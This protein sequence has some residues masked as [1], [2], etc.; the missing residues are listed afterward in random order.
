MNGADRIKERIIT[1]AKGRAGKI[2]EAARLEAQGIIK[3]AEKQAFQRVAIMTEKAKEEAV[4]YKQRFHAAGGMEDRKSILKTRQDTID[5]AFSTA[6]SRVAGLPDDKYSLF[7][8]DILFKVIKDDEGTI[9]L[10]KKDKQRLGQQFV[11]KVN[12][13]LKNMGK[14]AV[15]KLAG[16]DLNSCG[17]FVIRYGVM[18]INCTLEV[19][20]NMAR[21]NLEAEVASI[22]FSEE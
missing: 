15:L 13:K 18:E 10:N 12:D 2:I 11:G 6:L 9:V 14:N 22:L 3:D 1:D 19:I 16:D 21:P 5:E 8:E 20:L 7:I 17:G 4:L